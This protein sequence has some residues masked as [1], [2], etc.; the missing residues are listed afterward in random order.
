MEKNYA[1]DF[2]FDRGIE[3]IEKNAKEGIPFAIMM[4]IPGKL[5][6]ID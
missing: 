5:N 3:F 6:F 1:T 2:L 4:S